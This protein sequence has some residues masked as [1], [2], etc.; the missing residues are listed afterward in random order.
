MFSSCIPLILMVRD[1]NNEF[2]NTVSFN[3]TGPLILNRNTTNLNGTGLAFSVREY[4][5]SQLHR[6][7]EFEFDIPPGFLVPEH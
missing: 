5:S 1:N 4:L 6:T 2:G 3:S 7:L